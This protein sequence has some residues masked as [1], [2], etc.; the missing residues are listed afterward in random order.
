MG[1]SSW[2][3]RKVNWR[4]SSR[5][6]ACILCMQI[7]F[8]HTLANA[9]APTPAEL[10]SARTAGLAWLMSHQNGDGGWQ[11]SDGSSVQQT[12]SAL[13]ALA[14]AG[15]T[16]GFAY[17]AA[18]SYLQNFAPQSV[19]SLARQ[20]IALDEAGID[21]AKKIALLNDW[22]NSNYGW[23]AYKGYSGSLPDTA[24]AVNALFQTQSVNQTDLLYTVCYGSLAYAQNPDGSFPYVMTAATGVPSQAAGALLPTLYSAISL[25]NI[26]TL[27]SGI[28][29]TR[30]SIVTNFYFSTMLNDAVNWILSK[31]NAADGG[32]GNDGQS[33]VFDTAVA[34]QVLNSISPTAYA[35]ELENASS[36][37][38]AQQG[39]DGNWNN[40]P[41]L[42]A[43][44]LQTFPTLAPGTLADTNANGVP[45]DVENFLGY[46]PTMPNRSFAVGNGHA[47]TGLTVSQL[48]ATGDQNQLFSYSI[49]ASGGTGP[50][51][52]AIVSGNLPDGLSLNSSN[53]VIDG[54]PYT[55]GTFNFDY[56]VTDAAGVSS[57]IAAQIT[58]APSTTAVPFMPPWA[59]VVMVLLMAVTVV[60]INRKNTHR[61]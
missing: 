26:A 49:T 54:T 7:F 50:Y 9:A 41:L 25:Q 35:A 21:V 6:S 42:T 18:I 59:M 28:S 45:D 61:I 22:E 17:S 24:L 53:G 38:I 56:S 33:T 19:D 2:F 47:V 8:I 57:S 36:Y 11:S 15:I 32:F 29:C 4:I 13:H 39:I 58:I 52:W 12:I 46:D 27:W 23:G 5:I 1:I 55:A 31:Q 48:L 44:A 60:S 30:D 34:Y 51:T 37:L 20:I 3:S 16:Q 43:F 14:N 10:D 40:D